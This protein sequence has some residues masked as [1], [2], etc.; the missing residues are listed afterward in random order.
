MGQEVIYKKNKLIIKTEGEEKTSFERE[1]KAWQY[2]PFFPF[3]SIFIS[4]FCHF[5]HLHFTYRQA[6]HQ[7]CVSLY[8]IVDE[9]DD[10][11]FVGEFCRNGSLYLSFNF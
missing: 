11:G 1:F 2:V 6:T 5:S 8:G 10:F 9:G 7:S 4:S 3:H